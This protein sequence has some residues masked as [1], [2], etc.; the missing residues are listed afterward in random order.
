MNTVTFWETIRGFWR[1]IS[2][3]LVLGGCL[4]LQI[5]AEAREFSPGSIQRVEDLP[6]GRFRAQLEGLPAEARGRAV[7]WLAGFHFTEQDL[8]SLQVDPAGGVFYEDHF[9]LDTNAPVLA[10]GAPIL[11]ASVPVAPFPGN[12]LFHSRAGAPNVLFLNFCGEAVSNTAWNT[13]LG[14]TV[15]PAAPF[16]QDSDETTFSDTEQ[17]AIK[18]IW[19]RVAE[20][21]APFNIDVT[22]ERPATFNNRTAHALI[23]RSTDVNGLDNPSS[24]AGG[25]GYVNVFGTSSYPNYR[26]V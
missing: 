8:G 21:Y 7:G 11:M 6:R 5:A 3:G 16:S 23:T 26:P 19:E 9:L 20:D 1:R 24:T 12:L 4:A 17:Q 22:T 10:G 25:V 18:R 2:I 15:I 13:S 14:R